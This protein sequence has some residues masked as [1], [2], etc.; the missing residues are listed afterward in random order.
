MM[1]PLPSR[2]PLKRYGPAAVLGAAHEPGEALARWMQRYVD[3]LSAKRGLAAALHSGNRAY[4]AL[5]ACF[6]ERLLS[7]F[8]A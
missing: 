2:N 4:N 7:A 8:Q 1:R 5:P 3:F 6:Q